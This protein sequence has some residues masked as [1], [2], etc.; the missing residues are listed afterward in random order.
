MKLISLLALTLSLTAFAEDKKSTNPKNEE[1]MK[2]MQEY[3]TPTETH[4]TLASLAGK[5]ESC[6]FLWEW[7]T[8]AFFFIISSF[9]GLVLFLSS[10][11]AV[12]ERVKVKREISFIW[13]PKD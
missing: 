7:H 4:K 1:M 9:L 5:R 3:A 10:A 2:K 6:E 12:R 8:P 11:K 13:P